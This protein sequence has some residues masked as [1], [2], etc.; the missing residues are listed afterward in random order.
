MINVQK[1]K[2]SQ[3]KKF[4]LVM[5]KRSGKFNPD[6][7]TD[8]KKFEM[9]DKIQI[10]HQCAFGW[11]ENLLTNAYFRLE[12]L[13]SSVHKNGDADNLVDLVAKTASCA[14]KHPNEIDQTYNTKYENIIQLLNS[15]IRGLVAVEPLLYEDISLSE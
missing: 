3:Y 5:E 7:I 9:E 4:P 10:R 1:E 15:Q 2:E 14:N 6:D 12:S 11:L 13:K 8:E